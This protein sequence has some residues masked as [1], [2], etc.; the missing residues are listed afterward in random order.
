MRNSY[1]LTENSLTVTLN[2]QVITVDE[3]HPQFEAA[4]ASC[5]AGNWDDVQR[6]LDMG[7]VIDVWS[8]GNI[9]IVDRR[10]VH[11]RGEPLDAFVSQKLIEFVWKG[12]NWR[13]LARFIDNLM[14]NPSRHSVEQL[15]TFLEHKNLPITDDG[16]FLAYKAVRSNWLD[17]HSGTVSNHIGARPKMARNKVNDDP[18]HGCS[19]GFHV[20]SLQYV[21][22]FGGPDDIAIICKVNP[23]DVVSVPFDCNMQKVRCCEY[24][25]VGLYTGPLPELY[26]AGE[27]LDDDEE[28]DDT[29]DY[30]DDEE[31]EY[32]EDDLVMHGTQ[33]WEEV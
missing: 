2:G 33:I 26:L 23:R 32:T 22:G 19:Y 25:V 5:R 15:Y 9:E 8:E 7:S 4:I 10:D 1:L 13:P 27:Y 6:S 3:D 16:H 31:E 17:K 20:G 24:E 30:L 18:R 12:L 11:Y 28:W 14:A 21:A 29:E